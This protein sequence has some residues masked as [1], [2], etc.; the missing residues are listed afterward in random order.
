MEKPEGPHDVPALAE[1]LRRRLAPAIAAGAVTEKRMFGGICLLLRGNM[2]CV[3]GKNG[4]MFRVGIERQD[5][6]ARLPG[7][8]PVFMQKRFMPGFF[9]A[10]PAKTNA[11]HLDTWLSL[12]ESYVGA[13][14]AKAKPRAK[15]PRARSSR[16]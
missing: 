5:R 9:R 7:A 8:E 14:P 15:M 2:L 10:D 6:A 3:A 1:I 16:G 12:A 4:F 11:K 13:L